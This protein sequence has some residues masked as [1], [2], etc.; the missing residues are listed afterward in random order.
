LDPTGDLAAARER[1]AVVL[2][3][4][5][6]AGFLPRDEADAA[7]EA[8]L[9][10]GRPDL[11][12]GGYFADW[13]SATA[14]QAVEPR[15]GYHEVPTT[16][17]LR[18][19]RHAEAVVRRALDDRGRRR[20]ATQAAVVVMTLDGEVLAMV[21]GRAY[22]D[23]QYNRATQARRQPGS[24]FKLFVYLA[25]LRD[26][27]ALEDTVLDAP[28]DADRDWRPAN[29]DDRYAGRGIAL[30]D[31]FARSSNVAAVRLAEAV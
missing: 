2:S 11:P 10:P 27:M 5:V 17:D 18:L 19:Q 24:V 20:G 28:L 16:L 15:F 13:V 30:R 31:A 14:K 7:G 22:I 29:H 25:A 21:G 12:V 23:S 6:D 1:A 3:A 26:G 4:M 9:R 8:R